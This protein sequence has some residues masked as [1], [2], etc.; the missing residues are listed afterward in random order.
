VRDTPGRDVVKNGTYPLLRTDAK[1]P[2]NVPI[3]STKTHTLTS[4]P[5]PNLTQH[6]SYFC[7]GENSALGRRPLACKKSNLGPA[8]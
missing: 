4:P 1:L 5:E 6:F 3:P 2:S 7:A 8:D